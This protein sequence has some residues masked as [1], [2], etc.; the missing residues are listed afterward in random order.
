MSKLPFSGL[1]VESFNLRV[2]TQGFGDILD[3]TQ[4]ARTRLAE[5]GIQNGQATFF[6]AGATAGLT[7]MEFEPGLVEDLKEFFERIVPRNRPYHH[8]QTWHDGNGFSHVRASL[9]KPSLTVPVVKGEMTLGT[10]QQII[11]IDF[12]NR[13][14]TRDVI[15]Q[16]MGI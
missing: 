11:L 3:V 13:P 7:A 4:E 10:W 12:D 1:K 16:V 15:F 8:E 5:S 6:V 14:R 9:L 2:R